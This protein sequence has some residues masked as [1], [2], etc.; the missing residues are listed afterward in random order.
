MDFEICKDRS[1]PRGKPKRD[2]DALTGTLRE[3]EDE[4]GHRRS[5][6]P[7]LPTTH[8]F[9]NGRAGQVSYWAELPGR[10]G[11]RRPLHVQPRGGPDPPAGPTAARARL[12]RP[13]DRDLIDESLATLRRA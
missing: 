3:A 12:T 1:H 9:V 5:P 13:R 4:T 8:H 10:R 11:G 6:G 7:R 2:E